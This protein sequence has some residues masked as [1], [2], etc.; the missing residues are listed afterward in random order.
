M[1]GEKQVVEDGN[2]RPMGVAAFVHLMVGSHH[3]LVAVLRILWPSFQEREKVVK[4]YPIVVRLGKL[5][6]LA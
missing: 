1:A 4:L 5:P 2:S 6:M 3:L